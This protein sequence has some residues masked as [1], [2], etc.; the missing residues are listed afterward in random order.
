MKRETKKETPNIKTCGVCGE[1]VRTDYTA[2]ISHKD[3]DVAVVIPCCN[4][5]AL[6]L[7]RNVA[8]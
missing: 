2:K 3:G 4:K 8:K 6:K 1:F 5:C 7:I